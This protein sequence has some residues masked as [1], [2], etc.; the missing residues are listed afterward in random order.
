M[1]E[2]QRYTLDEARQ[3]LARRQCGQHGHDITI[4]YTGIDPVRMICDNACGHPGWII[5]SAGEE[6]QR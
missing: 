2:S 4:I 6:I 1:S 3:V 5:R